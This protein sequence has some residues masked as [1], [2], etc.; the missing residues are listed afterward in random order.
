MKEN[1]KQMRERHRAEI[2]LLQVNCRHRKRSE[3]TPSFWAPGHSNGTVKVCL[4]CG[5]TLE[6]KQDD[7]VDTITTTGGGP[8]DIVRIGVSTGKVAA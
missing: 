6:R 8:F 2:V 4:R 1:I 3:W 5:K 7:P